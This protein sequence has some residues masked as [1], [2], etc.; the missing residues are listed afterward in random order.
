MATT[1][2]S[3]RKARGVCPRCTAPAS[4]GHTYCDACLAASKMLYTPVL[5]TPEEECAAA[6]RARLLPLLAPSAPKTPPWTGP[7]LA[8]CGQEHQITQIPFTTPCCAKTWFGFAQKVTICQVFL[9]RRGFCTKR[10]KGQKGRKT[11]I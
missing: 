11:I 4:P 3:R 2:Y 1:T 9:C 8:C 5:R 7:T 6:N 10:C